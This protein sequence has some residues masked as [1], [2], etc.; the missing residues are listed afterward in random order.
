MGVVLRFESRS[1]WTRLDPDGARQKAV[2]EAVIRCCTPFVPWRTGQLA[3]SP[4]KLSRPG[5]VVYSGPNVEK[6][7]TRPELHFSTAVH[8]LAGAYWFERMKASCLEEIRE[9]AI[10]RKQG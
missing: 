4:L 2:D 6:L 1:N 10:G 9:A 3:R 5:L 7:Y 8:P